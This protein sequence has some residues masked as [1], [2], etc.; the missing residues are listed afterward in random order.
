MYPYVCYIQYT[1]VQN[2]LFENR[3]I[4]RQAQKHSSCNEN[5]HINYDVDIVCLR[6]NK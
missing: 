6:Q 4:T 2:I 3:G 1:I 5:A